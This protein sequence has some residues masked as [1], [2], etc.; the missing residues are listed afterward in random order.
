MDKLSI[1]INTV[2]H[3]MCKHCYTVSLLWQLLGWQHLALLKLPIT[4]KVAFRKRTCLKCVTISVSLNSDSSSSINGPR[5]AQTNLDLLA[6]MTSSALSLSYLPLDATGISE[7]DR[8]AYHFYQISFWEHHITRAAYHIYG[9]AHI[10]KENVFMLQI[11]Q[12]TDREKSISH[13]RLKPVTAAGFPWILI[14]EQM[15]SGKN[16][17]HFKS[18][19]FHSFVF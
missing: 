16:F 10:F 8:S 5:S 2:Y 15:K 18:L 14:L 1:D 12:G 19:F 6:S 17:S 9:G 11:S 13:I 7:E 4:S 3:R